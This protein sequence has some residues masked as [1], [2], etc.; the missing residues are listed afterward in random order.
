MENNKQERDNKME[1][2][3]QEIVINKA[4]NSFDGNNFYFFIGEKRIV[5]I[6]ALSFVETLHPITFN[7]DR[8][9]VQKVEGTIIDIL[10]DECSEFCNIE[11]IPEFHIK[12]IHEE[13]LTNSNKAI[14]I[15]LNNVRIYNRKFGIAADDI[16]PTM[17]FSF[18]ADSVEYKN[19]TL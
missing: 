14:D 15:Q 18:V 2:N 11:T 8:D 6:L 9:P 4:Y 13:N 1:N 10:F 5:T 16:Q 19:I 7:S 12:A 3:K 17:Q